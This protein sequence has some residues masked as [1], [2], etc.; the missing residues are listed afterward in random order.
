MGLRSF[1]L[2]LFKQNDN[3]PLR[4]YLEH[5]NNRAAVTSKLTDLGLLPAERVSAAVTEPV[6]KRGGNYYVG[7][8][9][10]SHEEPIVTKPQEPNWIQE[11]DRN[12]DIQRRFEKFHRENPA[13]FAKL[14]DL[15]FLA[16]ANGHKHIGIKMLFERLRWYY[17]VE[18]KG[19]EPYQLNNSYTSRYARKIMKE[20][21]ALRGFFKLREL[22]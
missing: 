14:V 2:G 4:A 1:I 3:Q 12:D 8:D 15:S 21:P 18:V 17:T 11:P 10:A 22:Y 20:V 19:S 16:K 13:V 9:L 6:I 7:L 5:E